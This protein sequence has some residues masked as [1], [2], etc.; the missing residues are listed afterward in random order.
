MIDTRIHLAAVTN[1]SRS[2]CNRPTYLP[3]SCHKWAV[4]HLWLCSPW[5]F[6]GGPWLKE[7]HLPGITLSHDRRQTLAQP[8]QT[9]Q[10]KRLLTH[11][12]HPFL[13]HSQPPQRPL[14]GAGKRTP[15][16]GAPQAAWQRWGWQSEAPLL[17]LSRAPQVGRE[18][19]AFTHCLLPSSPEACGLVPSAET[20]PRLCHSHGHRAR[21]SARPR[22]VPDSVLR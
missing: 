19:P 22:P 10:A 14:H 13:P 15:A 6:F 21:C 3:H 20:P 17:P 4:G 1:T 9:L 8:H 2:P 18:D 16:E 7:K 11:G 5:L 12:R